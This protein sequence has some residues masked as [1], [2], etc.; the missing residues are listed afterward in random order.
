ML[1]A[2]G[3]A[4]GKSWRPLRQQ[5]ARGVPGLPAGKRPFLQQARRRHQLP[6]PSLRAAA[7]QLLIITVTRLVR[8]VTLQAPT[9][10][11]TAHTMMAIII[12]TIMLRFHII[13]S[14]VPVHLRPRI[15]L[16]LLLLLLT[17]LLLLLP[18]PHLWQVQ[19]VYF[20]PCSTG[21]E[22]PLPLLLLLLLLLLQPVWMYQAPT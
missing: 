10:L 9:H 1:E 18:L 21:G 16:L 14:R 19:V 15:H 3:G 13:I 6:A 8:I 20:S 17:L 2:T 22:S 7:Q 5:L 4:G 11:Q 12:I